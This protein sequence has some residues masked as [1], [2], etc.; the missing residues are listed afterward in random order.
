MF[1][2]HE[3]SVLSFVVSDK[4]SE[5]PNKDLLSLYNKI[6]RVAHDIEEPV[7]EGE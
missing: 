3:L 6:E 7:K 1:T 4:L 2:P 5:T